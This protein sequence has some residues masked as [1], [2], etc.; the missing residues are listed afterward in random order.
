M[1]DKI[2][3]KAEK[4]ASLVV[5]HGADIERFMNRETASLSYPAYGDFLEYYSTCG[6]IP[7]EVA[8]S[9]EGDPHQWV[10]SRVIRDIINAGLI[11]RG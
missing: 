1:L 9:P 3:S 11:E 6:E 4:F 7:Y 5:Q 10:N 8:K 2:I